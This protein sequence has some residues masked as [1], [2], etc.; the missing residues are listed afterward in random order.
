MYLSLLFFQSQCNSY[1]FRHSVS[2]TQLI[3]NVIVLFLTH[4]GIGYRW[5]VSLCWPSFTPGDHQELSAWPKQ[6]QPIQLDILNNIIISTPHI[7][8]ATTSASALHLPSTC[9]FTFQRHPAV[10]PSDR[11]RILTQRYVKVS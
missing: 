8:A 4:V 10:T 2:H 3:H 11:T 7:I 1:P 6:V 9:T 5:P